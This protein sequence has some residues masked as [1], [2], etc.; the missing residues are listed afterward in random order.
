MS[1]LLLVLIILCCSRAVEASTEPS[2]GNKP[3]FGEG[4]AVDIKL[5][6]ISKD[7][8]RKLAETG[9]RNVR[10]GINW[11]EVE[12][13]K[14]RYAWDS[15]QIREIVADGLDETRGFNYDD[16]IELLHEL[17]VHMS[18]TLFFGN[19]LYTGPLVTVSGHGYNYKIPA[20]PRTP[21]S[22]EAFGAFAAATAQH[23]SDLYGAES[24]TW[25]IW[26]EPETD[27]GFPPKTDGAIVGQLITETCRAI[28]NAVPEARVMSPAV[29][30]MDGGA[31]RYDFMRDLFREANPLTC[32]DA[33]TVH[34]YRPSPPET[35]LKDYAKL[36]AFLARWQP[37]RP[38][39]IAVDEWGYPL[40]DLDASERL[41]WR[42]YTQEE[43]AAIQL[44]MYLV[45]LSAGVPLTAIYE[46]RDSGPDANNDE[47]VYGMNTY[48]GKEKPA[49]AMWKH[50]LPY[51]KERKLESVLRPVSCGNDVHVLHFGK[52][53]NTESEAVVA[54]TETAK[55]DVRLTG[56]FG[57]ATDVFGK[58]VGS[59][60]GLALGGIPLLI[61]IKK[62][63]LKS[64]ACRR[65]VQASSD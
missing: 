4:L 24:F 7:E 42:N 39:P 8:I 63:N 38:V 52:R 23:Y 44:R 46:W 25:L 22:V 20:A 5:E 33:F 9:F 6:R 58:K 53:F 60:Q 3:V 16:M 56:T 43:H 14:G 49:I 54:W 27:G 41:G 48:D 10:I 15:E 21:E 11:P 19:T 57:V 45:N 35:A 55:S 17:D 29:S 32:L 12:K 47:H 50:V 36:K 34:P 13:Q 59:E 64:L 2:N 31:F 62:K 1:R 61:D 30:V 28:K 26:N 65:N 37:E 18:T 40:P 51:L